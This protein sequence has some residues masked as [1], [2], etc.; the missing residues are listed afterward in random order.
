[1]VMSTLRFCKKCNLSLS[2]DKFDYG[3]E[4]NSLSMCYECHKERRRQY[5]RDNKKKAIDYA[6]KWNLDNRKTLI[7]SINKYQRKRYR[8]DDLFKCI[9]NVS[10][11][12]QPYM[13]KK[14]W[15]KDKKFLES[16][17]CSKEYLKSH[18]EK[19]FQKDM[20][21]DNYGLYG[22]HIDHIIPISSAKTKEEVYKLCHYTNLQPLWAKDNLAK[23]NK[24]P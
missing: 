21:W 12:I 3:K 4:K 19:Q 5:Y 8:E 15:I 23:S 16:L 13:R 18:L 6:I 7:K 17:G 2:L 1:M 10:R 14:G 9:Y 20:S 24:M 22:W 11:R